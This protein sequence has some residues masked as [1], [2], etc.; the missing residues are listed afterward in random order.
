MPF[1]RYCRKDDEI[2]VNWL[3]VEALACA[4]YTSHRPVADSPRQPFNTL[5]C[6]DHM[7]SKLTNNHKRSWSSSTLWQRKLLVYL[8]ASKNDDVRNP[9]EWVDSYV[10][11]ATERKKLA[12]AT[13]TAFAL[14]I[15]G[16]TEG[17]D[18]LCTPSLW[19]SSSCNGCL[20]FVAMSWW[21]RH[22]HI[23]VLSPVKLLMKHKDAPLAV[24]C[25]CDSYIF[26]FLSSW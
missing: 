17:A 10:I 8:R 22:P 25:V 23:Q 15:S 9:N 1:L 11:S 7:C 16:R 2:A 4:R 14:G 12:A 24:R 5:N 21:S 20:H 26:S 18:I 13:F 3:R 6:N 19:I